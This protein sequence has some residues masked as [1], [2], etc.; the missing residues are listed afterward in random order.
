M[1]KYEKIHGQNYL[2]RKKDIQI[3][4]CRYFGTADQHPFLLN[5]P[6]IS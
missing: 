6:G 4:F 2:P 5:E 3:F 1:Q